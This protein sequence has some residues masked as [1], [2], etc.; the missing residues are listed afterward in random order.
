MVSEGGR[1]RGTGRVR[2]WGWGFCRW[3]G[4]TIS[5]RG[6]KKKLWPP[7]GQSETPL[8]LSHR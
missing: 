5:R 3:V 8:G 4:E 1:G 6:R 7:G 2:E